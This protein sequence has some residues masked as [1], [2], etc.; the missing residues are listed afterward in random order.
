MMRKETAVLMAVL[1]AI[2]FIARPVFA[3]GI[4]IAVIDVNKILNESNAGKAARKKMEARYAELKKKIESVNL[5]ARSM[6]EELD[7]QKIL[8]GK[9][10]VQEKEAALAAKVGELRQLTQQSEKE[11]Q[12]RQEE[13][14]R[15]VLKVVEGQIDK[16]V[17]EDKIDLLIDKGSGVVRVTPSLE[18]TEKV[19]SRVNQEKAGGK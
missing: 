16:V 2:L 13:L 10:K 4:K 6:K 12:A 1:A 11:M 15:D 7:K 17:G 18:I 19:L 5:E 14:T 9:E 8:L 3:E